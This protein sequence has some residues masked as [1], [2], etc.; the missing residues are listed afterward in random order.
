[1]SETTKIELVA[2]ASSFGGLQAN[3]IILTQLPV[4]KLPAIILLTHLSEHSE[5][6]YAEVLELKTGH[7]ITIAQDKSPIQAGHIYLAPG[8][9]HLLIEE[10]K[11]FALSYDEKVHSVRPSADVLFESLAY[12]FKDRVIAVV[13]TGANEDGASGLKTIYDQGGRCLIQTPETAVADNMPYAAINACRECCIVPVK[14]IADK[15]L[16]MIN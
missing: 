9:Y 6:K 8:G 10:N 1:M 11:C 7:K 15:V 12:T 16:N 3:A 4:K 13:L 14:E 5:K 2:I